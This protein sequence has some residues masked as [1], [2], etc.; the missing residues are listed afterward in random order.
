M[1]H[2]VI[3]TAKW[4]NSKR[5]NSREPECLNQT[6]RIGLRKTLTL[7]LSRWE[8]G[9]PSP[10]SV[11]TSIA[12]FRNYD[13][14]FCA[15][16]IIAVIPSAVHT[17]P[18]SMKAALVHLCT[19]LVLAP[20]RLAQAQLGDVT[21][22]GDPVIS[23]SSNSPGDV[24]PANAIDNDPA[25]K[26]VNFDTRTPA[27][28]PSGFVVSP[29]IGR[30]LINGIVTQSANDAP[31]RDPRIFTLEGC[32]DAF[33]G[34]YDHP[35]N[36]WVLIGAFTNAT[37][38]ARFQKQMILFDN[39]QPYRHYRW[40]TIETATP[41]GCCMQVAEVEL[42]GSRDVEPLSFRIL[43]TSSNQVLL[44]W[45]ATATN[46]LLQATETLSPPDWQQLL[47]QPTLQGDRYELRLPCAKP[48]Q[49]FRLRH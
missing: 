2:G 23:S 31:E 44:T 43:M 12:M 19:A 16:L 4:E 39:F 14:S 18:S 13:L 7:S 41:N 30:T 37:F 5:Q 42:L 24:G 34:G 38:T 20:G 48:V 47:E 15:L 45:P 40:V 8:K 29:L 1:G 27:P 10:K 35:T 26:Y 49:Y 36:T 17:C 11:V 25:T 6:E 32:D 22:P 28:T 46:V 21:Q 3:C 9:K 33:V